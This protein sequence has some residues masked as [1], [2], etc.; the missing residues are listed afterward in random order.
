MNAPDGGRSETG[1]SDAPMAYGVCPGNNG[2]NPLTGS[3][4]YCYREEVFTCTELE[5][6]ELQ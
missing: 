3:N 4:S 2:K 6:F 1:Y 5:V